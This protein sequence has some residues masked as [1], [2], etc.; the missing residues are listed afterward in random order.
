MQPTLGFIGLGRMGK[1]MALNL[2]RAG[3][4]LVVH[5]RSPEPVRNL[6]AAGAAKSASPGELA[7]RAG[8]VITMLPDTPDVEAVALGTDG[9]LE[10]LKPGSLFIDM[11]TISPAFA[12]RLGE[13]GRQKGVG[14]LDAPV[15]GGDVGAQQGTLSIMVGGEPA[16]FERAKPVFEALGKNV[17]LCGGHGA[18]QMVKA[19]N[20]ILVA[21][22]IAGVSEALTLGIKAGV[23][24]DRIVEV[25]SAGL[26]RCGILELRGARMVA[27]D[28][29]PGFR[30]RLHDKDLRIA[31]AAGQAKGV[32][33][34]TSTVVHE[35]FESLVAT[36]GGD[37][38]HTGLLTVIERLSGIP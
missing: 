33:L 11:S 37:L 38:D 4:P 2:L 9:A 3:F 34:P 6:V 22:T 15:S 18:G 7:T 36:G 28:F 14:V 32:A 19:C 30:S 16:D 17:V 31:L 12:V 10:G 20:Q 5:S 8:I 27:H 23:D 35:L 24:P 26:A 13:V 1:P 21:V 29:A 25:L